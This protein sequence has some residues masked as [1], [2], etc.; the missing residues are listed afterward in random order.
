MTNTVT[1]NGH[2]YTDDGNASTG[3]ANGGHRTR[4]IPLVADAVV[5]AG[6]VATN[7]GIATT[8]AGESAAS[9]AAALAS[10]Y[11]SATSATN[12]ASSA[13]AAAASAAVINLTAP[14]PIGGATPA[15][16]TFTDLA[17][18]G[19]TILGN[20][21]TDTLNVGNGGLVKDA[22]GNVGIGT[23]SPVRKLSVN[24]V[25]DCLIS[26]H[27]GAIETSVWSSSASNLGLLG[28]LSNASLALVSNG[29]ERA[30][31]TATGN[32]LIG[33]TTDDGVNKLQVNGGVSTTTLRVANSSSN[34]DSIILV[35]IQP[36]QG[37][38]LG[39]GTC[40]LY[41]A[42]AGGSGV[43][44]DGVFR[45]AGYKSSDGSAGVTAGPFTTIASITVKNGLITAI[46]GT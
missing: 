27:S 45:A 38:S 21:S 35:G 32:V 29:A 20:A 7:A 42:D 33:T 43:S 3:M 2:T 18:T 30:R 36:G 24:Q 15:A 13:A 14:G 40:N 46:T 34:A 1:I 44:T 10:Q 39:G 41:R 11:S 19:N 12:A 6:A 8:K 16:G 37:I 31:I 4:L 26:A 5:V 25:G 28:T 22:G 17:T 23:A 9:A